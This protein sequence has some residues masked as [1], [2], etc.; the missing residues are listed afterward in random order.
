MAAFCLLAF[1]SLRLHATP[2]PLTS[3]FEEA[4]KAYQAGEFNRAR[5]IYSSLVAERKNDPNLYY[6]LANTYYRLND[7]GWAILWYERALR[8][9]PLD[10]DIRYNLALAKKVLKDNQDNPIQ[11]I[12]QLPPTGLLLWISTVFLWI[13]A[14]VLISYFWK[15]TWVHDALKTV[16][17]VSFFLWLVLIGWGGFRLWDESQSW[18][19]VLTQNAQIRSGPGTDFVVGATIPAGLKVLLF[20][21][22][23]GWSLLGVARLGIKGWTQSTNIERVDLAEEQLSR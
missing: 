21:E 1:W 11:K 20:D 14:G 13:W 2:R 15:K 17:A 4:G 9:K 3:L 23:D 19:V 22:K 12:F 8:L 16:A 6:N 5:E 7:P 18:A 10:S